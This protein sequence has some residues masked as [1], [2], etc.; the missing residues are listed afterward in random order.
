MTDGILVRGTRCATQVSLCV[1]AA[2]ALTAVGLVLISDGRTALLGLMAL[3]VVVLALAKL[4]ELLVRKV[5]LAIQPTGFAVRDWNG[6]REFMDADVTAVGWDET[7]ELSNGVPQGMRRT[8]TLA[9]G[10]GPHVLMDY[11]VRT[12]R[13]DPVASLI[14]RL[15]NRLIAGAREQL[16]GGQR[17]AGS[18]WALDREGLWISGRNGDRVIPS[19]ELADAVL[20][21]RHLG[22]WE[23]GQE[24]PSVRIPAGEANVR[25]LAVL[26]KE[27]AAGRGRPAAAEED[28][29]GGLGRVLFERDRSLPPVAFA[30]LLVIALALGG[31]AALMVAAPDVIPTN[32]PLLFGIGTGGV[33]VLVGLW[34]LAHRRNQFACHQR[35]VTRTTFRGTRRLRY[36]DVGSF[37][38]W[39]SRLY[40]D[41][42]YRRMTVVLTFVPRAGVNGG[43]IKF[44]VSA[45]EA[46]RA[47]DRLRDGVAEVMARDLFAQ[48]A[49]GKGVPWT[50]GYVLTPQGLVCPARGL[51]GRPRLVAYRE[52]EPSVMKGGLLHLVV[53]GDR[54]H[55]ASIRASSENFFPG[56]VV[57]KRAVTRGLPVTTGAS[58]A[59]TR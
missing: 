13:P 8:A 11:S 40:I 31:V 28:L 21:D 27:R 20:L 23:R 35:G 12:G 47:L 37:T 43:R 19:N 55:F 44:Y 26:L 41:G 15:T 54:E 36:E 9:V 56:L 1:A 49:A 59:A 51:F 17:F 18:G 32:N 38:Y 14:H 34:T 3:L 30:L 45:Y 29:G 4:R 57:L 22:V 16:A 42:E 24:Q 6:H 58:S 46:D 7:V 39:A 50:A 2:V 5:Y 52:L 10:D 53:R 33:A 48:L 25:V